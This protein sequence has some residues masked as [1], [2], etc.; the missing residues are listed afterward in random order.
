MLGAKYGGLT[1][2]RHWREVDKLILFV[3]DPRCEASRR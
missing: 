3:N 1:Q 2:G